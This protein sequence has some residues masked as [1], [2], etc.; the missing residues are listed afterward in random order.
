MDE[1]LFKL[2]DHRG[3]F[4]VLFTID[5]CLSMKILRSNI[6]LQETIVLTGRRQVIVSGRHQCTVKTAYKKP[7][8]DITKCTLA[9]MLTHTRRIAHF[10][11]TKPPESYSRARLK[12]RF[13]RN[14]ANLTKI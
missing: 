12:L 9:L 1:I 13:T 3:S 10:R 11:V 2:V 5:N 4:I 7:E 6:S 8:L 14:Q